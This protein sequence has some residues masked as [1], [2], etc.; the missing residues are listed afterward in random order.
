MMSCPALRIQGELSGVRSISSIRPYFHPG[1]R[2]KVI[3]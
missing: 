3:R 1:G 2:C